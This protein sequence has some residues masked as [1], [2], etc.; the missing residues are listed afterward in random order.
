MLFMDPMD[1]VRE[2]FR[3][4]NAGDVAAMVAF[5]GP[6]CTVEQVCADDDGV[7][8]GREAVASRWSTEIARFTGALAGGHRVSVQRIAGMETGWGWVRAEWTRSL[9]DRATGM[10]RHDVGYSHFWI[11]RGL[12]QRHRSVVT[13]AKT[14]PGVGSTCLPNEPTPG[15][16]SDRRYPTRPMVGVGAVVMVEDGRIVL[17]KRRYEPLAGQ[18]SLPG[19]M[20]ELGETLEAATAREI[21]EE[22]GLIVDVGPVVEVFD[23][24][25]VDETGQ[26][27]YHFVL[28]D[29]LCRPRGGA[30]AAGSDVADAVLVHPT[31]LAEYRVTEKAQSVVQRALVMQGEW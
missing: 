8:E 24:I 26:V 3:A 6:G 18:W 12:I 19:G 30:L 31:S 11:E 20:L 7:Y 29:Y 13:P 23:R 25:L 21:A 10:E 17:V 4:L 2:F 22:T 16:V 15:V 27:R 9:R 5:C 28:V 1:I 14:T